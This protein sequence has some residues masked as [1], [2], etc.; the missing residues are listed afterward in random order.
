[1]WKVMWSDILDFSIGD[2]LPPEPFHYKQTLEEYGCR[3]CTQ[4]ASARK[5]EDDAISEFGAFKF[6]KASEAAGH[7]IRCWAADM[8]INARLGRMVR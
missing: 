6:V 5:A 7:V 1:M 4:W 3:E 8:C 2:E